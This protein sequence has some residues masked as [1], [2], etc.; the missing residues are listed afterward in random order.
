VR[1]DKLYL[2]DIAE[3]AASVASFL[4]KANYQE[5]FANKMQRSAILQQLTVIGEAASKISKELK[6]HYPDVEWGD[7]VGFRNFAV[8]AYFSVDW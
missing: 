4:G 3:A 5:F 6:A 1:P 7:I 8:H 2:A